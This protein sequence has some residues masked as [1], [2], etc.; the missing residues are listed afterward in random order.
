[1]SF[2][3][4]EVIV[5]QANL[6][7]DRLFAE[8]KQETFSKNRQ[9]MWPDIDGGV[10]RAVYYIGGGFDA[11]RGVARDVV[12]V[13]YQKDKPSAFIYGKEAL[14]EGG[15]HPY[16]WTFTKGY[17]RSLLEKDQSIT[18]PFDKVKVKMS[19]TPD[20]VSMLSRD[21]DQM[22]FSELRG[23]IRML[24]SQGQDVRKHRVQLYQK[25]A[26][27]LSSLVFAL[28]GAPLGLRPQR[29][30]SAMGLGLSVVIIFG[31]WVL[32]HYMTILGENGTVSPAAANFIPVL[33]GIG[34]GLWLIARA[35]K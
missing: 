27:P 22:S 17:W 3:L 13:Q 32:M 30:S 16:E 28:I 26:L 19:R 2:V 35:A 31:Y 12:V 21:P 1:S 20:Q 10:T 7:H 29:S 9:V 33:A 15:D 5:P 18:V 25:I 11:A 14:W 24:E 34:V 8:L 4:N 6:A 23:F